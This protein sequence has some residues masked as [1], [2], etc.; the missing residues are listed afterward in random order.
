MNILN[1]ILFSLYFMSFFIGLRCTFYFD[2]EWDKKEKEFA[3]KVFPWCVLGI[4]TSFIHLGIKFML[5]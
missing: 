1:C 5:M 2:C 3:H 4:V